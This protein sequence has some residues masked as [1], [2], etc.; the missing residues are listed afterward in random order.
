MSG[1]PVSGFAAAPATQPMLPDSP[2]ESS[3]DAMVVADRPEYS[4]SSN[5]RHMSTFA[6]VNGLSNKTD[7]RD[8]TT[9]NVP[10]FSFGAPS[11]AGTSSLA[12]DL[13]WDDSGDENSSSDE[14][15][16]GDV[17]SI[18][19]EES[20][21]DWEVYLK[22][23]AEL[24]A[25][26]CPRPD[27]EEALSVL[28]DFAALIKEQAALGNTSFVAALHK[29]LEPM[30]RMIADDKEMKDQGGIPKSREQALRLADMGYRPPP[31][32]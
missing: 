23:L 18:T 27:V 16:D 2:L 21:F 13:E 3:S 7:Q 15:S 12:A 10:G 25:R 29:S 30:R 9:T 20:M 24:N 5:K 19:D 22:N 31:S 8:E 11:L 4:N 28:D 1:F 32:E 17:D 26:P 14:D 6:V